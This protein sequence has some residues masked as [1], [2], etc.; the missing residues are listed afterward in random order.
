M[1]VPFPV[2][3]PS[4][5]LRIM[6]VRLQTTNHNGERGNRLLLTIRLQRIDA[7]IPFERLELLTR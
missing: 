2:R 5:P 7:L 4:H 1:L 3:M 6:I